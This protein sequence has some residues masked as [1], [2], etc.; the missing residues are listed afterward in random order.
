[1]S[2]L[3][4][5]LGLL[6]E[7]CATRCLA[8]CEQGQALRRTSESGF[9]ISGHSAQRGLPVLGG[10]ENMSDLVIPKSPRTL[11]LARVVKKVFFPRK[12][13]TST[14][15]SFSYPPPSLYIRMKTMHLANKEKALILFLSSCV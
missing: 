13:G 10:Q 15:F 8:Y 4:N 7:L 1:M 11:L 12:G 9:N 2:S 6:L 5:S 14:S 3:L